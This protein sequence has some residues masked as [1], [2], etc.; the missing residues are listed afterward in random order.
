MMDKI[1]VWSRRLKVWAA[2]T[3]CGYERDGYALVAGGER[4]YLGDGTSDEL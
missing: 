1:R 3:A 4:V 2:T